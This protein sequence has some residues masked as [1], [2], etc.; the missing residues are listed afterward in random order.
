[1]ATV[2]RTVLSLQSARL[3]PRRKRRQ[4]NIESLRNLCLVG[5]L[6]HVGVIDRSTY[7]V[8]DFKSRK[9]YKKWY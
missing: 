9:K 4:L 2:L 6:R 8:M 7:V 5:E 3:G 1:M